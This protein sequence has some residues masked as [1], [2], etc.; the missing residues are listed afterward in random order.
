MEARCYLG[1]AYADLGT[2]AF[3]VARAPFVAVGYY[4]TKDLIDPDGNLFRPGPYARAYLTADL[5]GPRCYLF[6]DAQLV[7]TR[8]FSA[9]L[10]NADAGVAARPWAA[11]PRLEVRVGA[12]GA[13]DLQTWELGASLY[14]Q[15]RF[16]Y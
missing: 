16:V 3:D 11:A 6:A 13:Y 4:P 5:L 8:S 12:G 14:S 2:A 7:G 1:P 9:E 15:P 10:L